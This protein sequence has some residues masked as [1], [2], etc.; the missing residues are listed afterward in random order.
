MAKTKVME[1]KPL[2]FAEKIWGTRTLIPVLLLIIGVI[3]S[4]YS[5]VASPTDAAAVGVVLALCVVWWNGDLNWNMFKDSLIGATR[6]SCMIALIL[7]G[8]A[9]PVVTL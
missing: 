6:T 7:T 8:A 9:W 2:S 5:G 1:R 4:I 3:G